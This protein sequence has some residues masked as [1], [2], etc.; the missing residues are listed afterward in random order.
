ML[1]KIKDQSKMIDCKLIK[2]YQET[3]LSPTK[4]E[5]NVK[6]EAL[7]TRLAPALQLLNNES[8]I[9]VFC[10]ISNRIVRNSDFV[11]KCFGIFFQEG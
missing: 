7:K 9:L 10:R 2:L 11:K 3:A 6:T 1:I 4:L 5:L 8:E